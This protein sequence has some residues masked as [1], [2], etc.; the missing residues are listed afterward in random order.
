MNFLKQLPISFKG[1]LHHIQ[2]VNF[3]VDA[4]EMAAF[5]PKE[6]KIRLIN[7]RAMISMVNVELKRMHPTFLPSW[8]QFNYRHVAFRLLVDDSNL[9]DGKC[10]GVF[11]FR[12]F[13]NMPLIVFGGKVISDYNLEHASFHPEGNCFSMKKKESFLSYEVNDKLP[14]PELPGLKE[15]IGTIDRA[16]SVL[17]GKL[18]MIQIQREKWPIEAVHCSKFEANFFRSAQLE[19]VFIVK[20]PIYYHWLPPQF[21]N[22]KMQ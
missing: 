3:S 11:F 18:R 10:K 19:G 13:T 6:I 16:Y 1:E 5:I 20:E 4:G 2:L 8:M 22:Q 17:N 21:I 7:D 14:P 12:S 9:S 15:T